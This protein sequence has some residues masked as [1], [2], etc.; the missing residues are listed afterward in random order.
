MEMVHKVNLNIM[1][2][3][4]ILIL[5][6]AAVAALSACQRSEERR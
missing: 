4:R 1:K 6:M 5:A 3:F 2:K